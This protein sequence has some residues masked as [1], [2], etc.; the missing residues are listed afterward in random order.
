VLL[1]DYSPETKETILEKIS[2]VLDNSNVLSNILDKSCK[3]SRAHSFNQLAKV[4][5]KLLQ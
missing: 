4:W 2:E 1:P 3:W 5:I